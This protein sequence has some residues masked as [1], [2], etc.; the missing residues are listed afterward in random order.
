MLSSIRVEAKPTFES[1]STLLLPFELQKFELL[2]AQPG[3]TSFEVCR[4]RL[5]AS[6]AATEP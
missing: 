1:W 4:E 2:A 5:N 6:T 3:P